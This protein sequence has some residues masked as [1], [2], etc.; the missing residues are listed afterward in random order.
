MSGRGRGVRVAPEGSAVVTLAV[1][2]DLLRE[3]DRERGG[4]SRAEWIRA[5]CQSALRMDSRISEAP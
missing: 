5:A 3:I 2:T 1:G 4:T